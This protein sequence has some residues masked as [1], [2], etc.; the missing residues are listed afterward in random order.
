MKKNDFVDFSLKVHHAFDPNDF[1]V[2]IPAT[3]N[4]RYDHIVDEIDKLC[5]ETHMDWGLW[6]ED[7]NDQI[8]ITSFC[9]GLGTAALIAGGAVLTIWL[10]K[11]YKKKKKEKETVIISVPMV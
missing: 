7:F 11:K 10:V 8:N 1:K 5:E 9:I 2:K 4:D 6:Q 3:S